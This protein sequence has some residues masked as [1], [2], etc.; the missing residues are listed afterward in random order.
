MY[1]DENIFDSLILDNSIHKP[2]VII[3]VTLII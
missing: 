3:F 1:A 2:N